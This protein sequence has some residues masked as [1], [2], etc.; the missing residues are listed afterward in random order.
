MAMTRRY[1]PARGTI[2]CP[3]GH[4]Y[5]ELTGYRYPNGRLACRTCRRDDARRW[6]RR[7]RAQQDNFG[8]EEPAG[9]GNHRP[10]EQS[11]GMRG[12]PGAKRSAGQTKKPES[13]EGLSE[14]AAGLWCGI[15]RDWPLEAH[16]Q[17]LLAEALRALD[18]ADQARA[19]IE[20]TGVTFTDRFGQPRE[21]PACDVERKSRSQY[22][23]LLRQLNLEPPVG[24]G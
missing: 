10:V 24:V 17:E 12:A 18:R 21:N 15:V 22:A 7:H 8:L 1:D 2:V 23:A 14:R 4:E 19:E 3:R 16:E 20:R 11:T 9:R 5:D 6:Y 13:P